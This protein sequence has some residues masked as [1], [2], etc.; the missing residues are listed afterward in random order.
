M[1]AGTFILAGVGGGTKLKSTVSVSDQ[2]VKKYLIK[3]VILLNV[4]IRTM[5]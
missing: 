1:L 4:P 3:I 5:K 2:R